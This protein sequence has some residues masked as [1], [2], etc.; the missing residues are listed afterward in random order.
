MAEPQLERRHGVADLQKQINV[1]GEGQR[2]LHDQMAE[3]VVEQEN[4]TQ[5]LEDAIERGFEKAVDKL[6]DKAQQRAAEHTG[7]W[8]WGTVRAVVSRWLVIGL[9]AVLAFKYLGPGGAA[10]VLDHVKDA[11]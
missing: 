5:R 6:I 1:L 11:K 10:A 3:L 2:V 8:L 7:R 9:I 4:M